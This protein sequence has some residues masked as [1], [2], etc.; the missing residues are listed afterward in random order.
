MLVVD[1]PGEP[2]EARMIWAEVPQATRQ[3]VKVESDDDLFT[4]VHRF[5]DSI[6]ATGGAFSL[7]SG[8]LS[9]L[10]IMTG[11]RG[12][13]TPM[14]FHGP[15]EIAAPVEVVGGAGMTGT[16]KDGIRT[17]HCHGAFRAASGLPVGGHLIV[18]KAIAGRGGVLLELTSISGACFVQRFDAETEFVIFHPEML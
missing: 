1:H 18:G 13:E 12:T 8:S 15:F 16:D 3:Q 10:S 14:T 6:D 17:S 9:S 5:L 4:A 7:I 2:S 11:G